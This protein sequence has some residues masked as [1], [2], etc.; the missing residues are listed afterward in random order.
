[1]S[2]D[3]RGALAT[4]APVQ[5][6]NVAEQEALPRSGQRTPEL[7][8]SLQRRHIALITLG[9]VIGAG[10]FVGSSAAIIAVGP[11]VVLSYLLAGVIMYAVMVMIGDLTRAF[12]SIQAFTELVRASAGLGTGFVA[13]W[14]YWY[15]WIIVM[16][17]EALA[18]ATLLQGW[19]PLPGWMLSALLILA[20]MAL[21]LLPTRSFGELEFWFSSV[22]VAAILG[23]I[24]VA[25]VYC[26]GWDAHRIGAWSN[27]TGQPAFMPHGFGSVLTGVV[28]VFFAMTGAEL[29][30][31]A[32]VEARDSSGTSARLAAPLIGRICLFYVG[33]VLLIVC[34]V[35][36]S[37]IVP[38]RSPFTL[39]LET[40]GFK[41]AETIMIAV[42]FTAI[43]SCL[44]SA[45]YIT[46]RV[47]FTLAAHG[48]A[49][50][51]LVKLNS[52]QVPVRTVLLGAF[53]ALVCLL[54]AVLSPN[55]AFV[56]LVNASGCLILFVYLAV[57]IAHILRP[58]PPQVQI[59]GTPGRAEGLPAWVTYL[60]IAAMVSLLVAMGIEPQFSSQLYVSS[61]AL[62]ITSGAY[63]LARRRRRR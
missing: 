1:L 58:K 59:R 5:Q 49:P 18:G 31:I 43:L 47:L 37:S 25:G 24:A 61:V 12:P 16:C 60:T 52:R 29:T 13:G 17:V 8:R 2:S 39:A 50:Q 45:F 26:L 10:L 23:F 38:G 19:I 54:T 56:F 63:I 62:G 48:D 40:I 53:V 35:P 51:P 22:K 36:W 27:L 15:L 7:S 46:S 33:S 28:T 3:G 11:A 9:G 41:T 34:V 20:M 42:I 32:A 44:N 4:C 6:T 30:T 14:L 21:N 57:C 55:T